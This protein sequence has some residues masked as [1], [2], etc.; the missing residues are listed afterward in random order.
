MEDCMDHYYVKKEKDIYKLSGK[1]SLL[2]LL[3]VLAS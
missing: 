1:L 3:F 2:L